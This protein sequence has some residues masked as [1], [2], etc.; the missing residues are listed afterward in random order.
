[1]PTLLVPHRVFIDTGHL[2]ELT[3]V[4]Q[5]RTAYLSAQSVIR[6]D[7]YQR[8]L[9]GLREGLIVPLI[10]TR[11]PFEWCT[12]GNT[13]SGLEIAAVLD[14]APACYLI[15]D[16]VI[17]YMIEALAEAVR[18]LK[19]EATSLPAVF[20]RVTERDEV[21]HFVL[22]NMPGGKEKWNAEGFASVDHKYRSVRNLVQVAATV[23]QQRGNL[24]AQDRE[25]KFRLAFRQS[26]RE[27][28]Q[29]RESPRDALMQRLRR[30]DAVSELAVALGLPNNLDEVWDTLNINNC[31]ALSLWSKLWWRYVGGKDRPVENDSD[32][33]SFLPAYAY[34]EFALTE[35]QMKH[36]VCSAD[37]SCESTVFSNPQDLTNSLGV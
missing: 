33:V 17:V 2:I 22:E 1:M 28:D 20:H 16:H 31:P 6:T 9:N 7:A 11:Q 12:D 13:E 29:E 21:T 27:V 5:D 14:L 32:D 36:F 3:K 34:S 10:G 35:R 18:I 23:N 30:I 8:I 4:H 19:P 24:I 15:A 25:D 37:R 26:R